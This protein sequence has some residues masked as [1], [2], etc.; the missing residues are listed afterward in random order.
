MRLIIDIVLV[1]KEK[2]YLTINTVLI[3]F[4]IHTQRERVLIIGKTLFISLDI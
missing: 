2:Q 1:H 3:L 4:E